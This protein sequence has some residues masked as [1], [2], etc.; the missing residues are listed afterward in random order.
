MAS[1]AAL[2]SSRDVAQAMSSDPAPKGQAVS[3]TSVPASAITKRRTTHG[4]LVAFFVPKPQAASRQQQPP[5]Q[6]APLQVLGK[7]SERYAQRQKGWS[8]FNRRAV[9]HR[10]PLVTARAGRGWGGRWLRRPCRPGARSFSDRCPSLRRE[11]PVSG[12]SPLE[13]LLLQSGTHFDAR[14]PLFECSDIVSTT[15]LPPW[16]D[17]FGSNDALFSS[18]TSSRLDAS[19]FDVSSSAAAVEGPQ[20]AAPSPACEER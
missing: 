10:Y 9:N 15:V 3:S 4:H 5:Q 8:K 16:L 2:A 7:K 20:I 14:Q 12:L 6:R 17:E 19:L 1:S 11:F 18:A 13:H